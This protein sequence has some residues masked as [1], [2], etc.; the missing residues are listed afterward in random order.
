MVLKGE[1]SFIAGF[2]QALKQSDLVKKMR[3][4]KKTKAKKTD[5]ELLEFFNKV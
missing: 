4:E 3:L 2:Y 1:F 5:K